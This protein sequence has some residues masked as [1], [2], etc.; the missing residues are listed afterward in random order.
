MGETV[1]LLSFKTVSTVN[2]FKSVSKKKLSKKKKEK[3]NN[4]NNVQDTPCNNLVCC[5]C[6][7]SSTVQLQRLV[8]AI[9]MFFEFCFFSNAFFLTRNSIQPSADSRVFNGF[10]LISSPAGLVEQKTKKQKKTAQFKPHRTPKTKFL[11]V[12]GTRFSLATFALPLLFFFRFFSILHDRS[13]IP[14]LFSS[15]SRP[16]RRGSARSLAPRLAH[17]QARAGR[18]KPALFGSTAA[19]AIS[20]LPA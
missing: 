10:W 11:D 7:F 6:F 8:V 18:A 16:V 12:L 3:N 15:R 17:P 20:Y 1:I 13:T 9:G 4:N 5:A 2:K 14:S 19:H